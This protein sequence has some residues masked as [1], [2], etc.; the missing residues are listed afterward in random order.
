M[1]AAGSAK[2]LGHVGDGVALMGANPIG[3]GHVPAWRSG[4]GYARMPLMNLAPGPASR[5]R[6]AL[7]L[8]DISGYTGF[9]QGITEAHAEL[10]S[11]DEEP[12]PVYALLSGLFDAMA[13]ALG[14]SFE[15]VK[16]EG[17]AIFA[18]AP[19]GAQS[20]RG[21]PVIACL[22][23]C[24]AAFAE[25]LAQG[26]SQLTCDCNSCSLVERLDLKF[27]LHHGDYVLH[28]IVGREELAGPEVIVAHRLLKNHARDVIGARPYALLTDAALEALAVPTAEMAPLTETYEGLP[29]I[30]GHLLVLD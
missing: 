13:S 15:V 17:D 28:H 9:L 12:A 23:A 19:D 6:G 10:K 22:R 8:A 25:R 29:P 1:H 11:A 27:V 18:V 5:Q 3:P 2:R 20:V 7:L 21:T 14:P 26:R 30:P 24:Y 16:L 4:G